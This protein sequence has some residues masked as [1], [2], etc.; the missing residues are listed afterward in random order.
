[1]KEIPSHI[2]ITFP[3]VR[4]VE[5]SAGSGKTY[6]LAARYVIL[7]LKMTDAGLELPLRS[8]LALTFTNKAAIEMKRRILDFIKRIALDRI[9]TALE[10]SVLSPLG[11]SRPR[12][13]ELARGLMAEIIGHYNF[14]QVE[15]IDRFINTLLVSCGAQAGLTSAFSIRTDSGEYIA[16]ALDALVDTAASDKHVRRLFEDFIFNYLHVE[17]RTSWM[18]KEA[19]LEALRGLFSI[20]NTFALPI[21][22]GQVSPEEILALKKQIVCDLQSFRQIL[23][24]GANGTFVKSLDKFLDTGRRSFRFNDLSAYFARQDIPVNKGAL[25]TGQQADLWQKIHQ[26]FLRAA[27]LEVRHLYDPYVA[28][29]YLMRAFLSGDCSREDVL[30]LEE[31]NSRAKVLFEGGLAVPDIFYRLAVRYRHYLVDEFQDTSLLQWENL[32]LLPEDAI[33]SGGTLFYVGDK[34][35]A[36]Y[37]FRGGEAG[38]FDELKEAYRS[39]N[40]QEVSLAVN[41]R[42]LPAVVE[43]NNRVF[44]LAS[45]ERFAAG[46]GL[47]SKGVRKDTAIGFSTDDIR[48]LGEV[49]HSSRQSS[50]RTDGGGVVRVEQ[51]ECAALKEE[52]LELVRVRI[53]S[54]L[55]SL[56]ER[57]YDWSSVALLLRSN[58]EVEETARWLLEEGIPVHSERLSS[59]REHPLVEEVVSFLGFLAEPQDSQAFAGF[60]LGDIFTRASG[61]QRDQLEDMILRW[62]IGRSQAGFPE[63]LYVFFQQQY[64]GLWNE[65]LDDFF[66]NFG[67]YP[68]YEL[69]VSFY[70]RTNALV[71]CVEG[72]AFLMRFLELVKEK[73]KD[74]PDLSGFLEHY[75]LLA[76]EVLFVRG[77]GGDAVKLLTVHK[78]KGLEFPV[79]I[80]PLLT[81]KPKVSG[82]G[83]GRAHNYTPVVDGDEVRLLRLTQDYRK[84]SD[85]ADEG[86]AREYIRS[87]MGELNMT[88][89]ALTRAAEELYVF[90]PSRAGRAVNPA[91]ALIP[92]DCYAIGTTG[93]VARKERRED[94]EIRALQPSACRDWMEYLADEFVPR[95]TLAFRRERQ[96]GVLRHAILAGIPGLPPGTDAR[97]A[98][99]TAARLCGVPAEE[100]L[101]Q[102]L[103]ALLTARATRH[104]FFTCAQVFCEKAFLLPDGKERRPDRILVFKDEV[105]V[106]DFKLASATDA[107]R[108]QLREYLRLLADVYAPHRVRGFLVTINPVAVEEVGL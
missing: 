9:D 24:D 67:T 44:D 29:Y 36:I 90:I 11:L 41:W 57:G 2:P 79:T 34:K 59:I 107:G 71:H 50:A 96:E 54:L 69:I 106:V 91:L 87:L 73:E 46:F 94:G 66:C 45:L 23:P 56:K 28:I 26:G 22:R 6:A 63:S 72:Q 103:E 37:G 7:A 40:V 68:L 48:R 60:I 64:S 105:Q 83:D 17:A 52:T 77:P 100:S 104:F 1:M 8:I 20:E 58:S 70:R 49:F 12:A 95:E 30:F 32:R 10:Q 39:Y 14:F 13:V 89:V 82:S 80:I 92:A 18:P 51:V 99:V 75:A 85:T 84:Y 16:R 98:L 25:V 33:S 5:A 74:Y 42:S 93:P 61:L 86:Y 21:A 97:E 102:E 76:G 3:E 27:D 108:D 65:L 19:V 43:F 4:V 78:A 35:Q 38:L 31:L 15:T 62:R 55:R 101:L 53:I 81:I 47:D 88:Y